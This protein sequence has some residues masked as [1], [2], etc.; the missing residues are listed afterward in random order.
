MI[1]DFPQLKKNLKADLTKL[2]KVKLALVGDT[3]TQLL[4]T[5]IRGMGVECGYNMEVFEAEYNQVER[6]FF[7]TS[8]ELYQ[9]DADFIVLFLSTHKLCEHHSLLSTTDQAEL[10]HERI[11]FIESICQ[12]WKARRLSVSISRRLM[13][14]FSATTP[15]KFPPRFLFRFVNLI[16]S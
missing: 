5:A 14:P 6:Q 15:I 9:F 4:V 3:A 2:P 7:D 12:H 8:S 10:A 13:M 1:K 11:A 16:T